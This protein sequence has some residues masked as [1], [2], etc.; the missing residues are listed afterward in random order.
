VAQQDGRVRVYYGAADTTVAVAFAWVDEL[1]DFAFSHCVCDTFHPGRR[2][3][4]GG[5]DP[6]RA[7]EE[8]PD[9]LGL[10]PMGGQGISTP[11]GQDPG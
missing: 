11:G 3:P 4:L 9:A 5:A 7:P 2:C 10:R 6:A 8:R 1:V